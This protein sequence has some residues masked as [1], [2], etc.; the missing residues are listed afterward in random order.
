MEC[1]DGP[2]M[3]PLT[4]LFP[5]LLEKDKQTLED[6]LN[7]TMSTTEVTKHLLGQKANFSLMKKVERLIPN[8]KVIKHLFNY[9]HL[10][11]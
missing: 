7:K 9:D 5:G 1:E 11:I 4:I 6:M 8:D 3:K 10:S 2:E